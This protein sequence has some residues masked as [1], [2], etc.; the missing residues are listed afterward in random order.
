MSQQLVL[1][2]RSILSNYVGNGMQLSLV[3]IHSEV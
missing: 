1:P 3:S 2:P